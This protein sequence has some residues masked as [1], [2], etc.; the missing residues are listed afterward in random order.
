MAGDSTNPMGLSAVAAHLRQLLRPEHMTLHQIAALTAV[1][2]LTLRHLR[3]DTLHALPAGSAEA[4]LTLDPL[5]Y[6]QI[7]T[8]VVATGTRRRVEALMVRGWSMSTIAADTGLTTYAI[9]PG[10]LTNT[11]HGD[12]ARRVRITF[13]RLLMRW[14]TVDTTAKYASNFA[15]RRGYLPEFAWGDYI[16]DPEASPDVTGLSAD[17]AA[18]AVAREARFRQL[19]PTPAAAGKAAS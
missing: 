12:T 5:A 9:R 6:D 1:D 8:R 15:V 10:R 13:G 19:R 2:E 7:P 3:N 11:I 4:V 17:W 14:V 18:A 16:D